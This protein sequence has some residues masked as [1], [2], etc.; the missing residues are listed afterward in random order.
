MTIEELKKVLAKKVN[1]Q[2]SAVDVGG[3]VAVILGELIERITPANI[4]GELK[5]TISDEV[6][7][8]SDLTKAACA[9]ALGITE[10]EL[11]A[12]FNGEYLQAEIN[13]LNYTIQVGGTSVSVGVDEITVTEKVTDIQALTGDQLEALSAG[14]KVVKVDQTGEHAYVVTY[15]G[16]GGL[17]LTYADCE[18]VETIAYNK[19]ESGWAFD[20]KTVTHIGQ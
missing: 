7:S 11:D 4:I 3:G 5:I 17:C 15:K 6:A 8:A 14:D 16:E 10:D 13:G 9:E 1:G 20:D 18:N 19:T 2:G 12:L